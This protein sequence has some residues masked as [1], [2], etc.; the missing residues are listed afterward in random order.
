MSNKHTSKAKYRQQRRQNER[1]EGRLV[2][3]NEIQLSTGRKKVCNWYGFPY[4]LSADTLHPGNEYEPPD[5]EACCPKCGSMDH[6]QDVDFC[7]E[8]GVMLNEEDGVFGAVCGICME[9]QGD[10]E[11]EYRRSERDRLECG[12]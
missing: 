9:S 2:C 10:E 6:L 3:R 8:C 5:I 12:A 11:D 1:Q 7:I 4:E